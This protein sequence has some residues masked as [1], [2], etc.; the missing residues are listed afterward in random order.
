[1]KA[2]FPTYGQIF[3]A[4]NR[5]EPEYLA[6]YRDRLGIEKRVLELGSG[7]GRLLIPL[8]E[9]CMHAYGVDSDPSTLDIARTKAV[10]TG[11][12]DRATM[13][14]ADMMTCALPEDIDTVFFSCDTITMI[15]EATDRLTLLRHIA[16]QMQVG[17]KLLINVTHPQHVFDNLPNRIERQGRTTRGLVTV[18]EERRLDAANMLQA[19]VK[20]TAFDPDDGQRLQKTEER[21]LGIVSLEEIHLITELLPLRIT[22]IYGGY[23]G[24][25]L[26]K[27]SE[28]LIVELV[29]D[30]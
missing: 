14:T 18:R 11:V 2:A 26:K 10:E 28:K 17:C 21:T 23:D 24:S 20:M 12:D 6:F 15:S 27:D 5:M 19:C 29:K 1:M 8:A 13:L 25:P 3:D 4:L 22:S 9:Q 30:G 7:T 16:R